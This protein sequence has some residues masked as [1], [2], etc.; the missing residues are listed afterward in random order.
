MSR[1]S[2]SSKGASQTGRELLTDGW[3]PSASGVLKKGDWVQVG[4]QLLRVSADVSADGSGEATIR[5]M[6]RLRSSPADNAPVVTSSPKGRFRLAEPVTARD[7]DMAK[8]HGISF[9]AVEAF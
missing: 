4:T 8:I 6:P 2:L 9:R 1:R 5:F 7:V 3:T